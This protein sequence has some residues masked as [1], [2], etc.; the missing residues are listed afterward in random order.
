MKSLDQVESLTAKESKEEGCVDLSVKT[1][2]LAD[3]REDLFY[4]MAELRHPILRMEHIRATL[5]DIFLE[6]TE[7]PEDVDRRGEEESNMES[8]EEE[9]HESNL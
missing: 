9:E 6:L 4:K 3:I 1:Q 8:G 5:E 7:Q 2:N